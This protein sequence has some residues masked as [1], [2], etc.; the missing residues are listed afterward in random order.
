MKL[1]EL[2]KNC[3]EGKYNH[4]ENGGDYFSKRIGNTLY[5][6]F[7]CSNGKEDWKNNLDF[8]ARPYDKMGKFTWFIH[9]GFSR[10]WKSVKPLIRDIIKDVTIKNI[11]IV[12]YS[13]GAALAALCHEYV[14]FN[15]PDLR[16][17]FVGY[18]FGCPRIFWGLKPKK[19]ALR[20][21]R[22]TVIRNIDDIVT[23][24][25]P[26]LLGYSHVGN[27]IEIGKRGK[28]SKVDAHRPENILHE[29]KEIDL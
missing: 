16:G 24:V 18:G 27:I 23:H 29:L 21:K 17:K 5:I 13:H 7:Q 2:F 25:P 6:Y 4:T 11:V 14:W 1:Y 9:R 8:P 19:L 22:F 3:V 10:V 28:Y 20:W 12:G 15:R 26:F